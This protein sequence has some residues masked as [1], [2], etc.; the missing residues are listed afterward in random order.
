MGGGEAFVKGE[1]EERHSFVVN[2]KL[3]KFRLVI[4]FAYAL[5]ITLRVGGWRRTSRR[6][7]GKKRSS[8]AHWGGR[9]RERESKEAQRRDKEERDR[10]ENKLL[11]ASLT[12]SSSNIPTSPQM[13]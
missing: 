2:M 9:E 7:R 5:L 8:L 3:I 12:R 10:A 13:D 1:R 11:V 6:G 4:R